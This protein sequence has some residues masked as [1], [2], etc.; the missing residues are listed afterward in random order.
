MQ[1]GKGRN[2]SAAREVSPGTQHARDTAGA[3]I[4]LRSVS[5]VDG[6]QWG[7][8][9]GRRAAL[10][11]F[12]ARAQ[13]FLEFSSIK[14]NQEAGPEANQDQNYPFLE[15]FVHFCQISQFKQYIT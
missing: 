7:E 10:H 6:V 11:R 4:G 15:P 5:A 8:T 13:I 9:G 14:K 2:C 12:K 3:V 1:A